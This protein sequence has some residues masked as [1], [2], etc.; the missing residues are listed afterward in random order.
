MIN[1][2]GVE[3]TESIIN[4]ISN[5][6]IIDRIIDKVIKSRTI[7]RVINRV[8]D[9]VI[10]NVI[11]GG[12]APSLGVA[13]L[14]FGAG[15]VAGFGVGILVTQHQVSCAAHVS[16]FGGVTTYSNNYIDLAQAWFP[17]W[18]VNL[19]VFTNSVWHNT[20]HVHYVQPKHYCSFSRAGLSH[21]LLKNSLNIFGIGMQPVQPQ[22][23]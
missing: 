19:S 3:H 4:G 23:L 5:N 8:I 6:R 12:L 1:L 7:D 14:G 10:N 22:A 16:C 20:L 17:H 13:L 2:Y 9:R 15:F 18:Y 11:G 21:L